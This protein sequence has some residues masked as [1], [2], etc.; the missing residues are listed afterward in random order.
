MLDLK[1]QV[2][3]V[4]GG[5]NGIGKGISKVLS[6]MGAKVIILDIDQKAGEETARELEGSFYEMDVTKKEQVK[7]VFDKIVKTHD[8]ID[9]LCS[10]TGIFPQALL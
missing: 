7:D 10:N 5:A 4:T 9:I 2:A 8:R 6:E 1:K 3:V